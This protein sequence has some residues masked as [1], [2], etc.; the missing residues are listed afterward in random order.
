M[1]SVRQRIMEAQKQRNAL[2]EQQRQIALAK[3]QEIR[4]RKCNDTT[5]NSG[6]SNTDKTTVGE[7]K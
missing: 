1:K 5:V 3:I 7:A 6:T 2:T 4:N